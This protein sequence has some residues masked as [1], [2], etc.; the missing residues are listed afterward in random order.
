VGGEARAVV[1]D[2]EITQRSSKEMR[3]SGR[4]QLATQL[5]TI[6]STHKMLSN[7]LDLSQVSDIL[8]YLN[9]DLLRSDL[10]MVI[11]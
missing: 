4:K 1:L 9:L 6:A 7:H 5:E 11:L 2:I 10:V 8:N 3:S